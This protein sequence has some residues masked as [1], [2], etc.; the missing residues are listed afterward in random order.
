MV[1][2]LENNILKSKIKRA[3][4][5]ILALVSFF[6]FG[7]AGCEPI[8][9][10][11]NYAPKESISSSQPSTKVGTPIYLNA[12]G[13]DE[14]GIANHLIVLDN[15]N[16]WIIDAGDL[17]LTKQDSPIKNYSWTPT[18]AGT[19]S[20]IAQGTDNLDS[21]LK[22]TARLEIVVSDNVINPPVNYAPV[23]TSSP[24]FTVDE[25][26]VYNYQVT[27][28]DPE[29]DSLIC[30]VKPSWLSAN[31]INS[32]TW[33]V[34]GLPPAISADTNHDVEIDFS[35]GTNITKQNYV[36]TE[37]NVTEIPSIILA[38]VELWEETTKN[39]PLP[40]K[41][42]DGN[43]VSYTGIVNKSGNISTPTLSNDALTLALTSNNI[44]SNE[45]Y[46]VNL[47]F[48]DTKTG[49][50]GNATLEGVVVNLCDVSGTIES[51]EEIG[52]LK[53]GTI[54]L[55]DA[56]DT[57]ND[58]S[59][60]TLLG[61]TT[62]ENGNFSV[63][64]N[65]SASNVILKGRL[66]D[67]PNTVSSALP[68]TINF[69]RRLYFNGINDYSNTK[70]VAVPAFSD[71]DHDG[72]A[73]L[74]LDHDGRVG[75]QEKENF[76]EFMKTLN[77]KATKV[78]G[79]PW[80][81]LKKWNFGEFPEVVER[82]KGLILYTDSATGSSI[83]E[84]INTSG[85]LRSGQLN[86]QIENNDTPV[87]ERH[88]HTYSDGDILPHIGWGII[89]PVSSTDPQLDGAAGRTWTYDEYG[90]GYIDYFK[91]KIDTNWI[92]NKRVINHEV[93]HGMDYFG[94]AP[95][96]GVQKVLDSIM[97]YDCPY[98]EMQSADIKG[99]YLID[100]PNYKGMEQEDDV[101]GM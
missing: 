53:A 39:V 86:I 67:T 26:N 27:V 74:D 58:Y 72:W 63:Q 47:A 15:N 66:K 22:G 61:T 32:S 83:K 9:P 14:N 2:T 35:D 1:K 34:S 62:S 25:G 76:R 4:A 51:N 94:H 50:S 36:L 52:I 55:Y 82:Y 11:T 65:A 54:E 5:G 70:V 98:G 10:T 84:F 56:K 29:G 59:D 19:Y 42:T 23:I 57:P 89:I 97:G 49:K 64:A 21:S 60:D 75:E 81:G 88:Y 12:D 20:F 93:R 38:P 44:T 6:Y 43:P 69:S 91:I 90:D 40:S 31:Q 71:L 33:S 13:T 87:S 96:K 100:N 80:F 18:K 99:E 48:I 24:I 7:L 68:D 77:F 28:N 79:N 41:N 92:T 85:Y 30:A 101:V 78:L 17:E 37:K 45:N 8:V 46:S 16:N 3:K 95:E 73:D